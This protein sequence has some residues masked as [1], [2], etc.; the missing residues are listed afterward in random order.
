M[1]YL[2]SCIFYAFSCIFLHLSCM[3][4]PF[5][6]MFYLFSCMFYLFS[7]MFYLFTCIFLLLNRVNLSI[8]ILPCSI[9]KVCFF[10][11]LIAHHFTLNTPGSQLHAPCLYFTNLEIVLK[12]SLPAK[13]HSSNNRDS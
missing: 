13:R 2:L 5:S 12:V 9:S 11:A 3:F 8:G 1:F 6:C 4:Y 10:C 7:C